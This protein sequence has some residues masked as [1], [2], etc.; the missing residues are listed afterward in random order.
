VLGHVWNRCPPNFTDGTFGESSRRGKVRKAEADVRSPVA[1]GEAYRGQAVSRHESQTSRRGLPRTPVN[2][3][4]KSKDR[5]VIGP[6]PLC[7]S[8]SLSDSL[9]RPARFKTRPHKLGGLDLHERK[10][11]AVWGDEH[12]D[13]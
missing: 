12:V 2:K 11:T 8:G 7:F 6:G 4:K 1:N 5:D 10:H 13:L 3:A 9:G